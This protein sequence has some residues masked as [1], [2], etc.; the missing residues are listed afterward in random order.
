[1]DL[2]S[3]SRLEVVPHAGHNIQSDRPDAVIAAVTD[4]VLK[5][6]QARR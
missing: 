3:N 4:L 2:S 1:M 6:R 5:V